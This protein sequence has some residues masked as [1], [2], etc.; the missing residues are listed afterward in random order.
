MIIERKQAAVWLD[1]QKY[2]TK[3]KGGAVRNRSKK[4][5]AQPYTIKDIAQALADGRS[6]I[7]AEYHTE[8]TGADGN[9]D[10]VRFICDKKQLFF[11]DFD[12]DENTEKKLS[13]DAM[14]KASAQ[15]LNITPVMYYRTFSSTEKQE[16]Y[17]LVFMLEKPVDAD[18]ATRIQNKLL[19]FFDGFADTACRDLCR[20]FYGT[21][22]GVSI[23]KN[24]TLLPANW[25]DDWEKPQQHPQENRQE[26]DLKDVNRKQYDEFWQENKRD[27]LNH[28]PADDYETWVAVGM[29]LKYEGE[30]F[31]VYNEWSQKS[32]KYKGRDDCQKKWDSFTR[33]IGVTGGTLVRLAQ[34]NGWTPRQQKST[35]PNTRNKKEVL[36]L[37]TFKE[38]CA[39]H[40]ITIYYD[41]ITHKTRVVGVSGGIA[42]VRDTIADVLIHDRIKATYKCTKQLVTDLIKA[43]AAD[44]PKNTVLEMLE[45]APEWDGKDR[46]AELF[47]LMKLP[48]DDH[49]SRV[50]IHKWLLQALALL[51]NDLESPISP[52]GVLVLNGPQGI[53]KTLLTQRLAVLP[54]FVKTGVH[55]N[56]NDKDTMI[57]A[58]SSWVTELGELESTLRTDI[59]SLKAL[60]TESVDRYRVP[61]GYADRELPRRTSFLGT[62]NSDQFLID[63]TGSR[64]FWTVPCAERFDIDAILNFDALQLW[65]QVETWAAA[66]ESYR[67]TPNELEALAKRN[68]SYQKL[69]KA[70]QEI[71]DILADAEAKPNEYPVKLCTASEIKAKYPSLSRYTAEQIGKALKAEGYERKNGPRDAD[72]KRHKGYVF[73]MHDIFLYSEY[74]AETV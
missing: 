61:Y 45:N 31:E 37:D 55:L 12:N 64:R 42:E 43:A 60:I 41:V 53:G 1:E 54:D 19:G 8:K 67:L 70:Q 74:K 6:I 73:P 62:C 9:T 34:E 68:C 72:G 58:T 4:G 23:E 66:G 18:T 69:V 10:S 28:I 38:W 7:A 49:L 57:R 48:A 39:A 33:S 35:L 50:L 36:T 51:S 17:R 59:E 46:E 44:N 56:F 27:I 13:L 26:V 21:N 14:V 29:G 5:K 22:S 63:Q 15:Y 52:D 3:P 16:K 20:I 11:L 47:D 2:K 65:K 30:S 25:A 32:E 24:P 40:G 71:R